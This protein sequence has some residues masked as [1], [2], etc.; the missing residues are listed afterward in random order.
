MRERILFRG[1]QPQIPL[2]PTVHLFCLK[3]LCLLPSKL[4]L[5]M[6]D[7]QYLMWLGPMGAQG[8]SHQRTYNR[9]GG[10]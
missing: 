1:F 6:M 3:V 10:R 2:D 9:L 7:L 5:V 4:L 8:L